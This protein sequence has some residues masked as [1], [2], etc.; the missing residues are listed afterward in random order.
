M[1][2]L[3]KYISILCGAGILAFGLYN[4]HSRCRIS[5][6]GVLGMSLLLYR[7]FHISP[8]ISSLVMDG[9]ALIAGTI[10]LRKAFLW[11][12]IVASVAYSL[13]YGL[14]ELCGPV[15]P[16]LAKWPIVAAVVGGLFV[17][18]GTMLI[19]RHGCAAGADDTL[20]LIAHAKTKLTLSQFYVMS[21]LMVLLLSL[22]YIPLGRIGWSVLS[23][24]VSSAV[25]AVTVPKRK[26]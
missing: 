11:D 23:V 8:A 2:K 1:K 17:G 12:T 26:E 5:E 25:I 22:T 4:V 6:G 16:N 21:D 10:V 19:V 3:Y 14:F 7:W 15:L 13:W 9:A 18:V 24:L 20:A